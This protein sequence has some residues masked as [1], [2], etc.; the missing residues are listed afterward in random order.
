[1]VWRARGEGLVAGRRERAEV[2]E[3]GWG[4]RDG[5]CEGGGGRTGDGGTLS[6]TPRPW[7]S[8]RRCPSPRRGRSCGNL[9]EREPFARVNYLKKRFNRL[10]ARLNFKSC[11]NRFSDAQVVNSMKRGVL[12]QRGN[13]VF[14]GTQGLHAAFVLEVPDPKGFVIST[15]HYESSSWV[16]QHSTHPV[17]MSHLREKQICLPHLHKKKQTTTTKNPQNT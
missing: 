10:I 6:G 7:L 5:V 17:V 8:G 3:R 2:Q 12:T 1:M 14:M 4:L 16:K 15:A 13:K 9:Q 11:L